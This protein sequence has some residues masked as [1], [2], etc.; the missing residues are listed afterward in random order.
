V[1]NGKLLL[2]LFLST[3]VLYNTLRVSFTYIYYNI[4]PIGFVE[5]LCENKDKPEL[6]CNGKCHLKKVTQATQNEQKSPI[7][8]IDFKDVILYKNSASTY[9][10]KIKAKEKKAIY[11]YFNHYKYQNCTSCFHPP[12][13]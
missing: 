5:A 2:S 9:N 10:F 3:L 12:N 1:K 7:N 6:E 8:L 13:T 11:G 4:D